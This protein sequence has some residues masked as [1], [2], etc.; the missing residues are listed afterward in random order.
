[1]DGE[2]LR[3]LYHRL[4]HDPAL[5]RTPGCT[6]ADAGVLLVHFLAVLGNRSHR[7]AHAKGTWPLWCR[8]VAVPGYSQ[9]MKRLRLASTRRWV[10][11]LDDEFRGRLV[12]GG[13][14][15]VCD[16]KPLAV[17]G[18]SKD[19]DATRG[20]VPGGWA[21]GYKLHVL[22][23]AASG[24]VDAFAVT[25]LAA[26]EPTAMRDLVV[27]ASATAAGP[28]LAGA[29]VRGDANYDSN[30]L[31]AAVAAAGG[32]LVAPRARPG[33]GL[34]HSTPGGHHPDRLRAIA[35]LEGDPGRLRAHR[36]ARNC[37]EQRLAHLT[38]LPFGLWALPN[39]VRRLA[40]V[41]PWVRTKIMLYH[42]HLALARS[43]T[44]AA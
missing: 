34:G 44:A 20:K 43:N 32:R 14:G 12:G 24:A 36:R 17:G 22:V 2:L 21:R 8:H 10:G 23:D 42:L 37:V 33:T 18:Y 15:K 25:P 9:L 31:Y 39:F 3:A 11:V 1:M 16:G 40:R 41:R 13:G 26:G 19:P 28:A 4:F 7:S 5:T 6:Y 35:E 29:V 30:A 38:N 27:A